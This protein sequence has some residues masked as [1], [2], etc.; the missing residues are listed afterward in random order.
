MEEETKPIEEAEENAEAE[1]SDS[2]EETEENAEAPAE[3]T[4]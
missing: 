1:T 4:A 2:T 3:E